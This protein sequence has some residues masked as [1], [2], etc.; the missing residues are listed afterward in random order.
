M[1]SGKDWMDRVGTTWAEEWQ[2]TDRTFADLAPHLDAAIDMAAPQG[3]GRV[4]DIG[5]GAGSTSL[6]LARRRPD[7]AVTGIDISPAL[8]AVAR[9]RGDGIANLQFVLG[10]AGAPAGLPPQ[11]LLVSR[12]GVMFFDDPA[13][14]LTRLRDAAAPDARLV[15]SCFRTLA[16]NPW[17]SELMAALTGRPPAPPPGYVPGPFA[18]A[19]RDFTAGLLAAA[20]WHGID[21]VRIDYA[22]C[23]GA[24]A[25]PVGDALA[26]FA[27]IGPAAPLLAAADPADR[28]RLLEQLREV[29]ERYREG[30][31]VTMP[32]SAWIWTATA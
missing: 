25:D 7:L 31:M 10:D 19:D 9:Q 28:A 20:G 16:D 14:A 12:H 30:D 1:T 18:F 23:A 21:A 3:S 5:C 17:A 32:A 2:R 27:R 22:N 24:G 29:L 4:L 6:G 11:D 15:F 13:A 26:T 8:V